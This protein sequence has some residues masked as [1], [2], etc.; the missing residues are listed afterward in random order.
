MP[1]PSTDGLPIFAKLNSYYDR[2]QA[3]IVWFN[4]VG[5]VEKER[6]VMFRSAEIAIA[7]TEA[8]VRDGAPNKTSKEVADFYCGLYNALEEAQSKKMP[9]VR[10]HAAARSHLGF[11]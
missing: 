3:G 5:P 10:S 6:R 1:P 11:A 4:K 8:W 9:K 2:S 7:L